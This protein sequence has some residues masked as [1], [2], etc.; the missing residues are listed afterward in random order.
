MTLPTRFV[1]LG[2]AAS[3]CRGN[4]ASIAS[5]PP[6]ERSAFAAASG[7]ERAAP[8][9]RSREPRIIP[10][11]PFTGD[12]QLLYGDPDVP[13]EAFVM[14]IQEL[15]GGVAPP[16]SHPVDE[17]LTVVAGTWYLGFGDT[18][19]STALRELRSGSY[20]FAPK[21]ASMFGYARDSAIVQVS[22]IGPFHIRWRDGLRTLDDSM[23]ASP[24]LYRRGDRVQTPRGAGIIRQGYASGNIIQYEI[25][26]GSGGAFMAYQRDVRRP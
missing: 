5:R 11:G 7:V 9:T 3:A 4:G 20:A 22:G 24:F 14:R 18:F 8:D 1:L 16:H 25:Q 19:D 12:V 10:L 2:L 21:G 23:A 17:H 6:E 13:G 15:P 26:T